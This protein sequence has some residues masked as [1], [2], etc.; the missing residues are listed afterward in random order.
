M[1][2]GMKKLPAFA[3]M[4]PLCAIAAACATPAYVSPV[5]V[6]RFAG[7]A[8]PVPVQASIS[9]APAPGTDPASPEYAAFAAALAEQLAALGYSVAD[10]GGEQVALLALVQGVTMPE[11]RRGPVSVGGGAGVGSHGSGMGL[12]IGIDLTPRAGERIS[13]RLAVAIRMA[14]GGGNLWEGRAQ[15]SATANS[16]YGTADAAA[17]RMA[18]ALFAGFPGASGET[19][20][21]E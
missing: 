1:L 9:I 12:G 4:L 16:D 19:V 15:M 7:T 10:S 13:T 6:T 20:I 14:A 5:E 3:I 17:R 21:V 11:D 2:A 18:A 8:A